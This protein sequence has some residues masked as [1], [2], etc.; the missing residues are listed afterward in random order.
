MRL[1]RVI[2]FLLLAGM[3][4]LVGYAYF[5]DMDADPREMRVPVKLDLGENAAGPA[6][7]LQAPATTAEAAAADAPDQADALD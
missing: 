7:E 3:A 5:G 6:P 2:I 4:G 1:L